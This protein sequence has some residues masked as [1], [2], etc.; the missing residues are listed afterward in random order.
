MFIRIIP[1]GNPPKQVLDKLPPVLHSMFKARVKVFDAIPVPP[2]AWDRWRKQHDAAKMIEIL[3]DERVATFIDKNV[4]TLFITDTDI[5]YK[6]LTFVFGIENPEKNC[7]IVS[8]ARLKPEFYGDAPNINVLIE[9]VT[10]EAVH[11]LGHHIGL[12]HCPH[13]FCVMC[14]SPSA[15]DVDSK[16]VEFCNSCK[17]KAASKGIELE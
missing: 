5:F 1:V 13:P 16:R 11:E 12:G 15:G 3:C 2:E 17:L 8:I 14:Y 10:K 7:S 4:P 9:R 6:G